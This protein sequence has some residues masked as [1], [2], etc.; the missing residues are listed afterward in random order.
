MDIQNIKR[1]GECTYINKNAEYLQKKRAKAVCKNLNVI[2]KCYVMYNII[3][4][5]II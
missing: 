5:H 4:D 2:Y 3:I 1:C